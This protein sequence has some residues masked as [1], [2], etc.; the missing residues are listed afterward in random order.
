MK[1]RSSPPVRAS[2][3][4]AHLGFTDNDST[5]SQQSLDVF[6]CL[7]FCRVKLGEGSVCHS[8]LDAGELE[9]VLDADACT[10]KWMLLTFLG[11]G[12]G[13]HSNAFP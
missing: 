11:I 9:V 13:G 1:S 7:A 10:C 6:R 12:S 3:E 2:S 8:C 4:G 5:E